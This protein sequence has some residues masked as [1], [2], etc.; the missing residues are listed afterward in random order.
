[1]QKKLRILQVVNVRWFNATAWYGLRLS[2]LLQ[3]AGHDV[4]VI[5][6]EGTACFHEAQKM[7][8]DPIPLDINSLHPLRLVKGL[9]KL[10]ELL[11]DFSPDIVNCHRGEGFVFLALLK[12]L[13]FPFA[14]VRTRGDQRPPQKSFINHYLH[15]SVSDAL[16]VTNSP[17]RDRFIHTFSTPLEHVHTVLGGVDTKKFTYSK[18]GRARV[19]QELGITE[20]EQVVGLLGRFDT[21]KGHATLIQAASLLKDRFPHIRL[22]LAGTDSALTHE[23]LRTMAEE[24]CLKNTL[25]PGKCADVPAC[26]SAMDIGVVASIGSE[27]IARVALEMMSC[28][29]PLIGTTVGVMP[30]LLPQWAL[31]PPEHPADL[32]SCLA[33]VLESEQQ[34]E[35]LLRWNKDMLA[36]VSDESFLTKTLHVYELA[37]QK[38]KGA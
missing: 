33:K 9:R 3:D 28:G 25:F 10:I 36:T 21:V 12:K 15:N 23:E 7:G 32:A 29:I 22:M 17:M 1:M 37:M 13:G 6:L 24:A 18:A 19:R 4:R 8:I 20:K 11:R 35:L 34:K 16:I 27:T 2:R 5:C 30:D 31:V 38:A 14:L 26:I